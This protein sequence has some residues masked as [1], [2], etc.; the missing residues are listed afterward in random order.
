MHA[1]SM[2]LVGKSKAFQGFI[3]YLLMDKCWHNFCL[4]AYA[5][6]ER[7][8]GVVDTPFFFRRYEWQ[9]PPQM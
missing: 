6:V 3:I 8:V 7:L 5:F 9:G 2:I 1:G 4:L